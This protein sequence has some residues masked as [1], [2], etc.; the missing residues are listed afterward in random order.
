METKRDK[1]LEKLRKLMNLKESAK[2]LG[3]EG[4]AH[5][6]AAGIAR[7]LME[8]NL[9][10]EDIPEPVSYTHLRAHET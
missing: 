6:A 3:N 2:A 8:Y 4:E 9:S 5:A 7:L 10:E 1:I